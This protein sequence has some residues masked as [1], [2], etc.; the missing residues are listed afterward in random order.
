MLSIMDKTRPKINKEIEDLNN[1]GNT[2]RTKRHIYNTPLKNG[3]IHSLLQYVS[4]TWG[5]NDLIQST[6]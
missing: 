5:I 6:V 2:T 4:E 3:R 1:T